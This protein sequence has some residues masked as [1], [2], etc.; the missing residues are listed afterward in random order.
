MFGEAYYG[1][2]TCFWLVGQPGVGKSRYVKA[3]QPFIKPCSKWW[4]GY[5]G[6]TD[7]LIDDF[8]LNA[9]HYMGHFL[10]LWGDPYGQLDGEIKGG[11]AI[12]GF[13]RLWITSNYTIE[14]CILKMAPIVN[15]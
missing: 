4:D 9:M 12:L 11:R 2:R 10:K 13:H 5:N 15:G 6:Q 1:P 14:E 3:F 7:V 8:E